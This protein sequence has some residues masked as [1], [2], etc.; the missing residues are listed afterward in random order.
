[1]ARLSDHLSLASKKEEVKNHF[2]VEKDHLYNAISAQVSLL[3]VDSKK[4]PFSWLNSA[5]PT[6]ANSASSSASRL[7]PWRFSALNC[8]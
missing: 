6:N 1:M 7:R 8:F 4:D 3:V 2:T 5:F